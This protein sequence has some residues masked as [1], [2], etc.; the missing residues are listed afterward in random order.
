MLPGKNVEM[1]KLLGFKEP[2]IAQV[3]TKRFEDRN[4]F[5]ATFYDFMKKTDRG[6]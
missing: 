2:K 4:E 6:T 3:L 1:A 5:F